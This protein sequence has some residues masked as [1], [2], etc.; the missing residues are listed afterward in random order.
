MENSRTIIF[1]QDYC[2][3]IHRQIIRIKPDFEIPFQVGYFSEIVPSDK[4][5]DGKFKKLSSPAFNK[6]GLL[7]QTVNVGYKGQYYLEIRPKHCLADIIVDPSDVELNLLVN[8]TSFLYQLINHSETRKSISISGRL[9]KDDEDFYSRVCENLD[10]LGWRKF[11]LE[12][13]LI[14]NRYLSEF[15]QYP[16]YMKANQVASLIQVSEKTIRNWT[17]LGKIPHKQINGAV[18]YIKTDIEKWIEK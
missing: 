18:R 3:Q 15:D 16:K 5:I 13:M 12:K 14:E 2:E 1:E 9:K 10:D 17:S 4:I 8:K 11:F 7:R 6:A